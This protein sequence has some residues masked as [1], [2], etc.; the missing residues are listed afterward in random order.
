MRKAGPKLFVKLTMPNGFQICKATDKIHTH[1]NYLFR[2]KDVRHG[3]D[4]YLCELKKITLSRCTQ[5]PKYIELSTNE[6]C[7][8][9]LPPMP[10]F[11]EKRKKRMKFALCLQ[12]GIFG[13]VTP[14]LL[15]HFVEINKAL[16]A[17]TITIWIQNTTQ[18]VYT[19]LLPYIKSGL[20]ELLDWKVS[21]AMRS[22]GQ[23]AV[24][25]E[26]LY[27]NIH[28]AEYLVLHDIDELLIPYKHETWYGLL[29]YLSKN[30]TLSHYASLR[31]DSL[32]WRGR[33]GATNISTE[34]K[35]NMSL[36]YYFDK[37][38]KA[39]KIDSSRPKL[40]V[41][42]DKSLSVYTHFVSSYIKGVKRQYRVKPSIA[43]VHHYR[44]PPLNGKYKY[45]P[46]MKKFEKRVMP[47][48]NKML[49]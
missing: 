43:S 15:I 7:S 29:D 16:G 14:E 48:I 25:N 13:Y 33:D 32:P 8:D 4:D 12:K 35:C 37:N 27:R 41:S 30:V 2:R 23:F 28:R 3:P 24:N 1:P 44:I 19:T 45:D 6:S 18:S 49:C 42:L 31:F 34:M 26:C 17:S 46:V 5:A 47:S 39:E 21:V 38:Y 10:V 20:V 40:M 9:L 11:Y 22:Y 36:P